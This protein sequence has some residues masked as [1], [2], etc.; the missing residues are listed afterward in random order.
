MALFNDKL[1]TYTLATKLY[2]LL[3]NWLQKA[4]FTYK[5]ATKWH[6]FSGNKMASLNYKLLTYKYWLQNGII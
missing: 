3:T 6:D 1:F 4:L 2:N 5:L